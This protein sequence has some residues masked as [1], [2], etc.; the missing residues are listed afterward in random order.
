MNYH[1]PPHPVNIHQSHHILLSLVYRSLHNQ[2]ALQYRHS[3]L[4]HHSL[5]GVIKAFF[6]NIT[7]CYNLTMPVIALYCLLRRV[8]KVVN[9]NILESVKQTSW[10]CSCLLIHLHNY[11]YLQ[12]FYRRKYCCDNNATFFYSP[13]FTCGQSASGC[14]AGYK[15]L[16]VFS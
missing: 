9:H 1:S 7:M 13:G 6:A 16:I 12:A 14:I 15:C 10:S 5:K 11:F 2:T 4:A 3:F 8:R